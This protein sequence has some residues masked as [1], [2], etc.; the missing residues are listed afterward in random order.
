MLDELGATIKAEI[1]KLPKY[2]QPAAILILDSEFTVENG[3]LTSNLKLKRKIIVEKNSGKIALVYQ[4]MD[5]A[6][7]PAALTFY[8]REIVIAY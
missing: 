8:D 7:R 5:G 4:Y 3:E 6:G 2:Q 1:K